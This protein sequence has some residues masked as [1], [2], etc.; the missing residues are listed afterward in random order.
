MKVGALWHWIRDRFGPVEFALKHERND[1][2]RV[3]IIRGY[4]RRIGPKF[5]NPAE[6]IHM[7]TLLE[8]KEFADGNPDGEN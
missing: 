2:W 3:V 5:H 4:W 1:H 7:L 8:M 6:A